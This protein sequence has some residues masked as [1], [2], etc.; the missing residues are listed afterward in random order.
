MKFNRNALCYCGSGKKYKKCCM[1][2]DA[3]RA[4]QVSRLKGPHAWAGFFTPELEASLRESAQDNG[5]VRVA[6]E[7][8]NADSVNDAFQDALFRQHALCDASTPP[9]IDTAT[10]VTVAD[11]DRLAALKSGL[12][13]S[14]QT[15]H[16]VTECKPGKGIRLADRLAGDDRFIGD[17]ELAK[18]LEPLEVIIGRVARFEDRNILLPGWEKV[19]F[20]GRKA[21]IA[22]LRGQMTEAG[23]ADDDLDARRGWLNREAPRVTTRARGARPQ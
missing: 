7:A 21:A 6:A 10:T 5:A 9:L 19:Y 23:C 3:E 14:H 15:L 8:W 1:R 12:G 17:P 20:R 18:V 11:P 22:D 13:G 16:E 4:R 2:I